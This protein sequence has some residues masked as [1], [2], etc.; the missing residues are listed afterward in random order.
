MSRK[1]IPPDFYVC[2]VVPGAGRLGIYQ[3]RL[4]YLLFNL[5]SFH[6]QFVSGAHQGGHATARFLEGFLEGSLTVGAS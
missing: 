5:R 2:S 4:F 3:M 1:Q 6:L